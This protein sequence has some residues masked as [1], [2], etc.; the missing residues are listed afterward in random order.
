MQKLEL[1]N[2]H[3]LKIVGDLEK[4]NGEI[5]GTCVILHG[6][7]AHRN[8]DTVQVAKKG[9]LESGFQTFNFDA[10]HSFGE[11][12]GDFEKSSMMTFWEDFEDVTKWVQTQEWFVGPLALSG[13]SKGGYAAV[14]Y[15]EEYPDEVS[16]LVPIAPAISGKLSYQAREE[17]DPEGL[18]EWKEKGVEIVFG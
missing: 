6:W 4:P 12:D 16:Y 18:K 13:H 11:S 15:A 3:G 17:R 2:R 7:G 9:F 14:R 5:R 8:K 10:T 1:K